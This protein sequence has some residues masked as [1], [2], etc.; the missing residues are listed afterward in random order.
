[1]MLVEGAC[2]TSSSGTRGG[3]MC[4][5]FTPKDGFKAGR[6]LISGSDI[7]YEG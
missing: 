5:A 2:V 6:L 4:A 3:N 1:M 7:G